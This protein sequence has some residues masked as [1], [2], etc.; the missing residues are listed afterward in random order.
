MKNKLQA[1]AS[2]VIL[3]VGSF[4]PSFGVKQNNAGRAPAPKKLTQHDHDMLAKAQAKRDRK[5]GKGAP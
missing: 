5:A 4:F 3:G 1:L 2:A